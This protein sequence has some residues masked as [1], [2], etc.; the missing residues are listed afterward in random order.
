MSPY[1]V[2]QVAESA[3]IEVIRAAWAALI[4]ECNPDS[5]NPNEKRTR[6]LNEA[7]AILK[8]PEKRASLDQQLAAAKV[9]PMREP[10]RRRREARPE[11]MPGFPPAYPDAY[12]GMTPEHVDDAI[13]DLVRAANAPPIVSDIFKFAHHQARRRQ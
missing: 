1:Q 4:R 8:D 6:L 10:A 12:M 7:Y 3:S 11:S 5:P 13:E 9:K 2:L